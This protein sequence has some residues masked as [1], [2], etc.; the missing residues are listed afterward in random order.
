MEAFIEHERERTDTAWDRLLTVKEAARY[1]PCSTRTIRR[2]YLM[3]QLGVERFGE[4]CGR[5]RIRRK[6]L[7]AWLR[8]G[9]KT[10]AI[11]QVGGRHVSHEEL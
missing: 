11:T 8:N 6:A 3:G 4:G 1:V 9:G 5:V 2:A 7:E 10:R